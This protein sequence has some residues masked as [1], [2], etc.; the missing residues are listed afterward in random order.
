MQRAWQTYPL[1]PQAIFILGAG[2]VKR[3]LI[4]GLIRFAS[5]FTKDKVIDRIKFATVDDVRVLIPPN[6]MPV[7]QGGKG[8]GTDIS[9]LDWTRQRL[10][11]FPPLPAEF[12]DHNFCSVVTEALGPPSTRTAEE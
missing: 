9:S 11:A 8:T 7:Y 1:R 3:S 10:A 2:F 5:L 12:S 4:N 6:A